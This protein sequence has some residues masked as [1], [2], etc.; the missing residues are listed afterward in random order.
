MKYVISLE[1]LN[2][3]TLEFMSSI[4]CGLNLKELISFADY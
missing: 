2:K 3:E 1:G 4:S